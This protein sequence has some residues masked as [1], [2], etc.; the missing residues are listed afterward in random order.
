MRIRPVITHVT[1]NSHEEDSKPATGDVLDCAV[2]SNL[3]AIPSAA[4][5][6]ANRFTWSNMSR[7]PD[8]SYTELKREICRFWSG[9]ASLFH[10]NIKIA[11]GSC[12][13]LSRINRLII[14]RGV[15]SL[16]YTPQFKDYAEEVI[17]LGGVYEAL[18]LD[19]SRNFTFDVEDYLR[20]IDASHA[21]LYLDNPNNPTGQLV[22]LDAIE[23]ILKEARR[24]EILVIVDEAF[25][26]YV[27][28]DGSAVNLFDRYRNLAVTRTFTKGYGL[29]QLRVGYAILPAELSRY[30][31]KVDLPFPISSLAERVAV[32]ALR[33]GSFLTDVRQR[34][35]DAKGRLTS[36]LRAK[37]YS[38]AETDASCPI[39]VMGYQTGTD[40]YEM[41]LEKGI[42]STSGTEY[43]NLGRNYVRIN[44]PPRVAEFL[45]RL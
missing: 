6:V 17:I 18:P 9:R 40:L 12:E 20:R 22:S 41:L 7:Y 39:F 2:G 19:S 25:G 24:R 43:A 29:A 21:I 11:N 26:D 28:E 34:V 37:G 36:G 23:A 8:T 3:F 45:S 30:Y 38:I 13:I 14:E 1:R 4:L 27:E 15:K 31:A 42:R 44:T 5:E 16:G 10:E 32:E 35:K 33:D